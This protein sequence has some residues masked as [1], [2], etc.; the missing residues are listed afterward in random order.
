ML[1]HGLF[2]HPKKTWSLKTFSNASKRKPDDRDPSSGTSDETETE[3]RS[4]KKRCKKDGDLRQDVF[5]PRDLLPSAF[6]Q[7]RI[8][9]W[10]YDVQIEGVST[11]TSQASLFHH[12][13]NLL[14]DLVMLRKSDA[15]KLKPL[16]FIAHSLGGIVVKDALSLSGNE[17]TAFDATLPATVGVMFLGTPHHG[18]RAASL[19]KMV[20]EVSKLFFKKPN[21]QVLRGLETNSEILERISSSLGQILSTG[22]IKVHSFREELPT[23]GVMVV[24]SASSTIG[25]LHETRGSLHANHRNL[26]RYSSMEDIKFQRVV[27]VL[28]DWVEESLEKQHNHQHLQS[29]DENSALSD[30]LVFDKWLK[31][32]LESLYSPEAQT[33]F[34]DIEAAY[35]KTYNWLFDHKVGFEDWLEGKNKSNIYWIQGK[36]GS[37]KSTMMK[38]AINHPLTRELLSKYANKFWVIAGF[39]FH[40]RGTTV[41]K[42]A[43]GFLR[44]VLYQMI[45]HQKQLFALIYPVFAKILEQKGQSNSSSQSLAAGWT[46]KTLRDALELIGRKSKI[47]VNICLFV[48]ALDEHD[49][50]HRE[51]VSIL[52]SMAQLT[53]NPAFRVRLALAGRPENV[54]KTAFQGCPGFSIHEYTTEDIRHY[55]E[56]RIQAEMPVELSIE[57]EEALRNLVE[58]IV[59]KAQGVFL[60][61]RLVVDEI[62]EGICEGDTMEELMSLLSTIPT[63]LGELYKRALHHSSRGSLEASKRH[64]MKAYVMFQI[65]A[66]AIKPFSLHGLLAAT[67]FLTTGSDIYPDLQ[68]LSQG[69]MERRLN[70]RSAGLLEVSRKGEGFVQFIHQT[71]KEFLT[72]GLGKDLIREGLSDQRLETGSG[73]ILRYIL[74][75]FDSFTSENLHPDPRRFVVKNFV[76]T[77]FI[78]EW[79]EEQCVAD[80]FEP[81][82]LRL[83]EQL[84]YDILRQILIFKSY[85][86]FWFDTWY[87]GSRLN[88]C[89]F[90][91]L[92]Y[93]PLSLKKSLVDHKASMKREELYIL[94]E[95]LTLVDFEERISTKLLQILTD[96]G[97]VG[98][99]FEDDP[100]HMKGEAKEII[101][102][103][104][105]KLSA[106]EDYKKFKINYNQ[107]SKGKSQ[108]G[109]IEADAMALED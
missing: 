109:Q 97:V 16:I 56:D 61:V 68:R 36:P 6:P 21:L 10:G 23:H 83:P 52:T 49:G 89:I 100:H 71:V 77:A 58:D 102:R 94:L 86:D 13:E 15:A 67:H 76:T 53:A 44:E 79:I 47:E 31:Q 78:I 90:Y 20:F 24:G 96:E 60:W 12:S 48:D 25:Y 42:S 40:D 46:L 8:A 9:T 99:L 18:S 69:Q 95:A 72:A 65:V 92:C 50:N 64:K 63:E 28:Q 30:G 108:E 38:F 3:S 34:E 7:A 29:T 85:Q 35:Y 107:R 91:L 103:I 33:R 98:R 70:S 87:R 11:A 4:Q 88:F 27:S 41:Q 62:I 80:S 73:L 43:E 106:S 93:L 101:S 84:Q 59:R 75:L 54:F 26:A 81:T 14:S 17:R 5:W 66:C 45:H 37:G 22:R 104:R 74:K 55:A 82:I 57:Y 51:M 39:F 32:C 19:G 105:E 1:V 2:G